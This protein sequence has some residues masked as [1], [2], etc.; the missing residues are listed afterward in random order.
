MTKILEKHYKD[1]SYYRF[2]YGQYR[3]RNDPR[4]KKEYAIDNFQHPLYQ[5]I[6][7]AYQNT[8]WQNIKTFMYQNKRCTVKNITV[9]YDSG[10]VLR[11]NFAQEQNNGKIINTYKYIQNINSVKYLKLLKLSNIKIIKN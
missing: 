7:N 11:L 2:D 9:V 4:V 10:Y 5:F 3:K 1:G 6:Q 8:P